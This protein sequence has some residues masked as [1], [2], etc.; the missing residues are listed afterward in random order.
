MSQEVRMTAMT[1]PAVS[2]SEARHHPL[3]RAI[4]IVLFWAAGAIVV[5]TVHIELDPLSATGGAVATIA[6]IVVAAFC[7]TRFCARQAGISH[8]L[9]VGIVWLVLAIVTEMTLTSRLGHEWY[10]LI[11]S[12]DHPLLRNVFL[13]LWIF[14]PALFARGEDKTWEDN[15]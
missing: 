9:G 13:F 5:A 11:G 14:A 3:T 10:D 6:A 7:Y 2:F 8:A 1:H 12:P 15:A 4:L